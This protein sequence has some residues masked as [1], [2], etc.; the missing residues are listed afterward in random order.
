MSFLMSDILTPIRNLA[1][2]ELGDLADDEGSQN[3]AIFRF[4][5]I[6]LRKR[7]RQAYN[8]AFSDT[9]NITADGFQTFLKDA[10]AVTDLFEPLA[11]YDN[12]GRATNKRTAFDAPIGWWRESDNLNIHTK[13]MTGNHQMKYIRYPLLVDAAGDTVEYPLAGQWDLIM[14][15]VA[16]IKLPKNFYQEFDAIKK[17]ATG[18]ATVKASIAA[19]GTNSSPPSL[20]DREV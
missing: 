18:T 3:E 2:N 5:T 16:L 13:G 20:T 9:L 19:K 14:D 6:V 1:V 15:V 17:E 10:V 4:V 7:A 11:V 8:A 12:A